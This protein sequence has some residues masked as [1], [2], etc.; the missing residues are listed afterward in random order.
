MRNLARTVGDGDWFRPIFACHL[1]PEGQEF[2]C[3]GYVARHGW[4]NLAVRL[5]AL[6]GQLNIIAIEDACADLDL[7]PDFHTMLTAYEHAQR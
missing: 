7:W 1:S 3:V 5:Q 6:E 2:T 4:S